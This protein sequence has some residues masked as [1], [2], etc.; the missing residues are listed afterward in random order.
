MNY[1]VKINVK[2]EI[3][4]SRFIW[5]VHREHHNLARKEEEFLVDIWRDS[6]PLFW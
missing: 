1:T 6:G 3:E 2:D 5:L 4:E